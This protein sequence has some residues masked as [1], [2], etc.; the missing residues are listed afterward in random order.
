MSI[1]RP[2]KKCVNSTPDSHFD[3][4]RMRNR[5]RPNQRLDDDPVGRVLMRKGLGSHARE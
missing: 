3:F 1:T 2:V 5:A 4:L